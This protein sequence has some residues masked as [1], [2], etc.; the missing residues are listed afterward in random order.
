MRACVLWGFHYRNAEKCPPICE[1]ICSLFLHQTPIC[2]LAPVVIMANTRIFL[3]SL[4]LLLLHLK[5]ITIPYSHASWPQEHK[6]EKA[7]DLYHFY[8][9]LIVL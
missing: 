9:S 8:F 4:V 6:K 2:T 3:L 1:F 5:I 7:A